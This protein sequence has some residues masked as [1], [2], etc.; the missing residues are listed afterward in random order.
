MPSTHQRPAAM[1]HLIVPVKPLTRAKSRLRGAS[2][3]HQALVLA[4]LLDTLAA[5]EATPAVNRITVVSSD[6][7]VTAELT[8]RAVELAEDPGEL[9]AALRHGARP[10]A[11]HGTVAALQA[12][13][14][15]LRPADL[16]TA[17]AEAGGGRAFC[18]DLAGTGT[19]L[20]VAARGEDL[21]PRFGV[22]SAAAHRAGGAVAIT[23]AVPT[24]RCDVD[25]PSDLDTAVALGVG[26]HTAAV[27]ARATV[28]RPAASEHAPT[29]RAYWTMGDCEH[30]DQPTGRRTG[31]DHRPGRRHERR[32]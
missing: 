1:V 14:P 5:A 15:A 31:E 26:R 32:R 3:D 30:R 22:G 6:P 9:N 28:D 23:A 13:L 25:T 29:G 4:M 8:G 18:A 24:L 17:L 27:L 16:A 12:D 11:R 19:T 20:L 10:V 7:V 21:A 2:T